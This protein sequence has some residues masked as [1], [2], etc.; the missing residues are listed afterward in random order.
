MDKNGN[1]LS[2]SPYNKGEGFNLNLFVY[3]QKECVKFIPGVLNSVTL[4]NDLQ[5]RGLKP[6]DYS[7]LCSHNNLKFTYVDKAII[8]SGENNGNN[9]GNNGG[10]G[11]NNENNEEGNNNNN[12]GNNNGN[13]ENGNNENNGENGSNNENG[14]N[15]GENGNSGENNG[16]GVEEGGN[17][18]GSS[19][20]KDD[21][22]ELIVHGVIS[23]TYPKKYDRNNSLTYSGLYFQIRIEDS[24]QKDPDLVSYLYEELDIGNQATYNKTSSTG[25][26]NTYCGS[27]GNH[28]SCGDLNFDDFF[29]AINNADETITDGATI[30]LTKTNTS[31]EQ[32]RKKREKQVEAVCK[33]MTCTD[34]VNS[35]GVNVIY[36]TPKK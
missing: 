10:D 18:G 11:S 20:N 24:N 22:Y 36:I 32:E 12:N 2:V 16:G 15:N 3:S 28:S 19:G 1:T 26:N 4:I 30:T 17:G 23:D 35:N 21:D 5:P 6:F 13:N 14:G 31:S 27:F 25:Y 33:Q 34:G 7:T 8:S 29:D 9:N